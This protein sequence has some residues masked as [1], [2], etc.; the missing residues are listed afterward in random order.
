MKNHHIVVKIQEMKSIYKGYNNNDYA[1]K[2]GNI[3][4]LL[5]LKILSL[6]TTSTWQL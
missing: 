3:K 6:A 5:S 2:I 1:I 4:S